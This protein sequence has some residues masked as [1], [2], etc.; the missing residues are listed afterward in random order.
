MLYLQLIDA[1]ARFIKF[2]ARESI[3]SIHPFLSK[4]GLHCALV[5]LFQ[6]SDP[7]ENL[8]LAALLNLSAEDELV[9]NV[10]HLIYRRPAGAV[11]NK[12]RV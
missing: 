7:L 9:Q 10:V 12:E 5:Q 3:T 4:M 1:D 8:S 6:L 2:S 11:A